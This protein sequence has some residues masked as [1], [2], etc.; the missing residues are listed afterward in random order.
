MG[1]LFLGCGYTAVSPS[2]YIP[3]YGEGP[4][5]LSEVRS[6]DLGKINTSVPAHRTMPRRSLLSPLGRQIGGTGLVQREFHVGHE[7]IK[8]IRYTAGSVG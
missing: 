4:F 2:S 8:K 5:L 7:D 3:R 1:D 6:D